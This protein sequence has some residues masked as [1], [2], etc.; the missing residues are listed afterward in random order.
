MLWLWCRLVATTP[1]RP[2]AWEP[3]FAAGV[4]LQK[5]RNKKKKIEMAWWECKIVQLLCKTVWRFFKKTKIEL[6][7][8]LA[9]VLLDTD[10]VSGS[11]FA[12]L[13]FADFFF[14]FF[15]LQT[16]GLGPPFIEQVY[17]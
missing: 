17:W 14:F 3:P 16:G 12:L 9:I 6:P 5:Q 11:C 7:C 15:W 4:A 2:L 10:T 8:D 1:I 13:C